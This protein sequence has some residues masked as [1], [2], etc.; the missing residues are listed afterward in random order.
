MTLS[1]LRASPLLVEISCP[2]AS[3]LNLR[4]MLCKPVDYC[5][6]IIVHS[7]AFMPRHNVETRVNFDA[8]SHDMLVNKVEYI[9]L[10]SSRDFNS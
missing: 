4:D 9:S 5:I 7:E 1:I 3:A 6:I 2:C 8:I 10:S